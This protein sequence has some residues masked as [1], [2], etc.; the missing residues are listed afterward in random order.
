MPRC[1]KN[2]NF[3]FYLDAKLES[4]KQM[5]YRTRRPFKNLWVLRVPCAKGFCGNCVPVGVSS[6]FLV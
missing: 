1:A 5:K 4:R 2:K 6:L 3:F